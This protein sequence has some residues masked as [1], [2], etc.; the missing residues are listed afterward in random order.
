MKARIALLGA[1]LTAGVAHAQTYADH[2]EAQLFVTQ[3]VAR[4][5]F[6]QQALEKLFAQATY[7]EAVVTLMAPQLPGERSWLSYRTKLVTPQRVE[8][9][10]E[11]WRRYANVLA[12]AEA[13]YGVP[14]EIIVAIIGIETRYGRNTGGYRV[15]DA[16]ATLAFD[17]PR[18]ADYFRSE[19]EHFLLY[20][21]EARLEPTALK[22]S[23]AGAIGIPQFMPGTIRRYGV[24]FDRDGRRD[25]YGSAA[26]A[27]GSVAHFLA[28]HG[29]VRD[30]PVAFP[31][32]VVGE[33]AGLV[34]DGEVDVHYR[35]G[36]LRELDIEFDAR[37][38]DDTPVALI[39]LDSTDATTEYLVGLKNFYV[40]TRYNRAS[41]YGA[42]VYLLAEAVRT[43]YQEQR[44]SN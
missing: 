38:E 27:I 23:F 26:D 41:F 19:L 12:R 5:G 33:R 42:A 14:R 8:G 30:A 15:L 29:W 21:R 25:L 24:D 43:A 35:A 9:G 39:D 18:R 4:H 11:F 10:V 40:L 20:T 36:E 1:L 37:V 44:A 7:Q 17:Y 34:A 6:E 16:L 2:P 28:R 32:Q 31:A 3:M 13:T 22:G